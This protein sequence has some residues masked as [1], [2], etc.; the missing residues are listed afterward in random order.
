MT[1]AASEKLVKSSA[2]R[3]EIKIIKSE[4]IAVCCNMRAANFTLGT[5]EFCRV[6]QGMLVLGRKIE[7][8]A[9]F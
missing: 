1:T 9:F 5:L 6:Q 2:S 4:D 3:N 7:C 8:I